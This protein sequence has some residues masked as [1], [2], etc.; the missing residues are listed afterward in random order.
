MSFEDDEY[1]EEEYSPRSPISYADNTAV[2]RD[3]YAE[4]RDRY[5]DPRD[6]YPEP[7]DRYAEPRVRYAEPADRYGEPGGR[8][9]DP[10]EP[11]LPARRPGR[12]SGGRA[13]EPGYDEL[14]VRRQRRESGTP[15]ARRGLDAEPRGGFNAE[16][17]AWLDDPDFEPTDVSAP[18]LAGPDGAV[19]DFNRPELGANFDGPEFASST[20][21]RGGSRRA[22]VRRE[23][24]DW[25]DEIDEPFDHRVGMDRR[26]SIQPLAPYGY[27]T[28]D[29]DWNPPADD[30]RYAGPPRR[31]PDDRDRRELDEPRRRPARPAAGPPAT[32]RARVPQPPV[33][34]PELDPR[35]FG[36]LPEFDPDI[37]EFA[38]IRPAASG[39]ASFVDDDLLEVYRPPREQRRPDDAG[40]DPQRPAARAEIWDRT[41]ADEASDELEVLPADDRLDRG[42]QRP[43]QNQRRPGERRPGE[44]RPDERRPDE[45]R[46]AASGFV[47]DGR[48][49][50]Q[51]DRRSDG[52]DGF[53]PVDP[54]WDTAE[55]PELRP[56][57]APGRAQPRPAAAALGG[58]EGD[59]AARDT[60]ERDT[61]TAGDEGAGPRVLS[62]ATPPAAPRIISKAVPPA[63]PKVIK[64]A[65]PPAVPR[66]ISATPPVVPPVV[67]KPAE[68]AKPAAPLAPAAS[69]APPATDRP[70][71]TPRPDL[72]ARSTD[73]RDSA[74]PDA[75]DS[76][77]PDGRDRDRAGPDSAPLDARDR[78]RPD[79]APLD[80]RDSG[81][82]VAWSEGGSR[83]DFGAL[84]D[85]AAN[86]VI[87]PRTDGGGE[88]NGPSDA[89]RGEARRSMRGQARGSAPVSP[90]PSI[91]PVSSAPP[92]SSAAPPVSSARPVSS[93]PPVGS[94]PPAG[95]MPGSAGVAAPDD[96]RAV[97][98]APHGLQS[99]DWSRTDPPRSVRP[100]GGRGPRVAAVGPGG[101]DSPDWW[102][103]DDLPPAARQSSSM[104]PH[105]AP[106]RPVENRPAAQSQFPQSPAPRSPAPQTAYPQAPAPES[107]APRSP[108]PQT[109]APQA[110]A[111]QAPA[112]QTPAPA[113]RDLPQ[114]YPA[115]S[116]VENRPA[117]A[118][119]APPAPPT[120]LPIVPRPLDQR[121]TNSGRRP[122]PDGQLDRRTRIREPQAV[123]PAA[124]SSPVHHRA[125]PTPV[126]GYPPPPVGDLPAAGQSAAGRSAPASPAHA[127]ASQPHAPASQ[128]YAPVDP[129]PVARIPTSGPDAPAKYADADLGP[130]WFT[131]KPTPAGESANDA[132]S[133]TAPTTEGQAATTDPDN[134][135]VVLNLDLTGL[136][137]GLPADQAII[138]PRREPETT[139]PA[140]SASAGS[141]TTGPGGEDPAPRPSLMPGPEPTEPKAL[142]RP[143][144]PLSA[145]D[146]DAIRWRLD[147]GTL[148]EVVDD[149]DALRE[150]GVRLDEPLSQDADNVTRSGLLSVR[151][152]VYRL[153]GELGMAAAASRLALAHAESA[154]DRQSIVI[155]QAE[156]AHVLRLRGDFAEADRL[157]EQAASSESP[158][159][160]RSV[161][162]ENAGRSCFDQGRHMEALDHF[163][164]AIR[165]G[166]PEDTELVERI[167]VSLEAVYIHVLRDGWGPYPRMR[168]DIL[169]SATGPAQQANQRA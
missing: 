100:S 164:R 121:P 64:K 157:F 59:V 74:R 61:A 36:G 138:D 166:P 135:G 78:A 88:R 28:P 93:A 55:R 27:D 111:P 101:P 25:D 142:E 76:A 106:P 94:A 75:R 107:L 163:A 6:R 20:P 39:R 47:P 86:P 24:D 45:R 87:V 29:D 3:R 141:T 120:S 7:A 133:A 21:H 23:Q 85:T 109:P 147:G 162:H 80:A 72:S 148:R 66:V 70:D 152:E 127:P 57:A 2:A 56:S 159:I 122:T 42:T 155:A 35:R 19:L 123:P 91:S 73:A 169:G 90:A 140:D 16:R 143:L 115:A 161:V 96:A 58:V 116:P 11:V 32:G 22:P 126:N 30:Q 130:T 1:W 83:F 97:S 37:D 128:P 104:P 65:D 144:K 49:D 26:S 68:A 48:D 117:A 53:V 10:I 41:W 137:N 165:L 146:L 12:R 69:A 114:P 79:A 167:D 31:R 81:P 4:P 160:L 119:S 15:R 62:R 38:D 124:P 129:A 136:L 125:E 118:H 40:R 9:S 82:G 33:D 99:G 131:T 17:P 77:R 132:G 150:L 92:A 8:Y 156:L 84:P 158:G 113:R 108:A 154:G 139:P 145:G 14:A 98:P 13:P 34:V 54:R 43:E 105:A 63:I 50:R 51:A 60:D 134:P 168:R 110:L 149:R 103:L 52:R 112:P 46:P 89:P 67:A 71:A 151:A 102:Q 18:D 5:P 44:P 153:L 95:S